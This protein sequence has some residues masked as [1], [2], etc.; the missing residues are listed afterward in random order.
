MHG[1]RAFI[2]PAMPHCIH[3]FLPKS[4]IVHTLNIK[5]QKLGHSSMLESLSWTA[6]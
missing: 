3:A 4:E 1:H 2:N 6:A 5:L